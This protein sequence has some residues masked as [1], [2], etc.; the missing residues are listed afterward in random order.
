MSHACDAGKGLKWLGEF[1]VCTLYIQEMAVP[2]AVSAGCGATIVMHL[3][4]P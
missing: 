4:V 3:Q 2:L 1:P